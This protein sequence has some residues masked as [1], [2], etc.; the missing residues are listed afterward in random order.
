VDVGA[1]NRVKFSNTCIFYRKGWRGINIEPHPE[2]FKLFPNARRR[3][4]NLNLAKK[5]DVEFNCDGA[6]SGIKDEQYIFGHRNKKAS[7]VKV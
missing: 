3:D 5:S 7:V 4:I 6:Y 1:F 2:H